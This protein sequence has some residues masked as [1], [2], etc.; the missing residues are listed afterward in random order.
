[1]NFSNKNEQVMWISKAQKKY[2]EPI[3]KW[4]PT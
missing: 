3:E 1:M 4:P 2:K